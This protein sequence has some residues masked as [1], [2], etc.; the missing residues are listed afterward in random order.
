MGGAGILFLIA[1]G[2]A[3]FELGGFAANGFGEHSPGGYNMTSALAAE[4]FLTFMFLMVILG[5][6]HAKAPKGFAGIAI[7]LAL[8][9]N[10]SD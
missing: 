7:G 8:T 5:A 3:D 2:K 9:L 1:T 6:T 10:S 4:I